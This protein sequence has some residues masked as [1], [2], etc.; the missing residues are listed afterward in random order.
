MQHAAAMQALIAAC[1]H[2]CS[3]L[4]QPDGD[5]L[6]LLCS[7]PLGADASGATYHHLPGLAADPRVYK[8]LQGSSCNGQVQWATQAADLQQLQQWAGRLASSSD[9]REQALRAAVVQQVS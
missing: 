7:R 9:S 4:S 5:L 6:A 2:G 8:C 1:L 3:Q